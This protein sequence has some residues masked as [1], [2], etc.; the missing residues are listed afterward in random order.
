[1]SDIVHAFVASPQYRRGAMFINYDEWGG[2]FDHVVPPHV[3]DD[4]TNRDELAED[5]SL[6]GFRVPAV[7]V[8][9]YTRGGRVNHMTCTHESILKLISYRYGLGHLTKR[10]RYASNVGR[11]FRFRGKPDLEP[12]PLPDPAAIAALP[13]SLGGSGGIAVRPK[14]HDLV[15]LETS[16]LLDRLG[17]EVQAPSFERLFRYPDRVR[18]AFAEGGRR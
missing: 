2:F 1:M 16:G 5:W 14:E 6:A 3:P 12:P 9:P 11:S 8:S 4:R 15:G 18:K 10:H 13:C 7:A 17:F